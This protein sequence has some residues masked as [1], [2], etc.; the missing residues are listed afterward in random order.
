VGP[1]QHRQRGRLLKAPLVLLVFL[2]ESLDITGDLP[3]M[4][5]HAFGFHFDVENVLKMLPVGRWIVGPLYLLLEEHDLL[6]HVLQVIFSIL[7]IQLLNVVLAGE[8]GV[9]LP[10][11]FDGC[12]QLPLLLL[13]GPQS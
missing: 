5:L 11:L 12:P 7:Q 3:E 13:D 4:F 1:P 8:M 6:L 2:L 10:L 9:V